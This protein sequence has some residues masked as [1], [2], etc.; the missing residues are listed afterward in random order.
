MHLSLNC[1][2]QIYCHGNERKMTNAEMPG[3]YYVGTVHLDLWRSWRINSKF[4]NKSIKWCIFKADSL[5]HV[6]YY[7]IILA[8]SP[9]HVA[10]FVF[11]IPIPLHTNNPHCPNNSFLNLCDCG[12]ILKFSY[13]QNFFW[14]YLCVEASHD[15]GH[16]LD[17]PTSRNVF[18]LSFGGFKSRQ[19]MST[20]LSL[21]RPF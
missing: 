13:W 15:K 9:Y 5:M 14:L 1:F 16:R 3:S 17:C 4:I 12:F 6:Q 19:K 21:P 11:N 2:C 10:S 7:L 20:G 18:S 8:S